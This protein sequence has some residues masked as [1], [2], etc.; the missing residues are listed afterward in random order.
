[1][2]GDDRP[3]KL[4]VAVGSRNPVK[5][6]SVKNAFSTAFSDAVVECVPYDVP[7]G[8]PDQPWGDVETRQGAMARAQACHDAH[9][10]AL[11]S[12]PDY[13]VGLEGGCLE[14]SWGAATV[15]CFAFMAILCA[16]AT[17]PAQGSSGAAGAASSVGAV[18]VAVL[19]G[20][21]ALQ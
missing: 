19:C 17:A 5:I 1:M 18:A 10:A 12:A 2:V 6:N 3:S 7:S 20:C 16:T 15:S 13:A 9:V 11:G 21:A 14:E 4:V 8:V